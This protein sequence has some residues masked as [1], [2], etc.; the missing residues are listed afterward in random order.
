MQ[1]VLE[2]YRLQYAAE[3]P[4]VI[5]RKPGSSELVG[6]LQQDDV[7]HTVVDYK[8][9]GFVFAPFEGQD[10]VLLPL[11][12]ADMEQFSIPESA[13]DS[14]AGR[15]LDSGGQDQ[16][17]THEELVNSGIEAISKGLFQK[18]VLS[19][20]ERVKVRDFD[21]FETFLKLV[22]LYPSA[23]AY[24]FYHPRVGLWLGA[25]SEQLLYL[26]QLRF[27]T[28]AVAGTKV[29]SSEPISWGVKERREQQWVTD[30]IVGELQGIAAEVKVSKPYD[31]IAGSVV[32]L[33]TDISGRFRDAV[34]MGKLLEL[35][36]PTPAV[37]G[38][39]KK[40]A[41]DFILSH[42]GYDRKYYS[43]F[44]GEL[45]VAGVS[46]TNV[47]NLYVNLRC[48]EVEEDWKNHTAVVHSYIGGGIT[49]DSNPEKEWQE[50]VN[51]AQTIQ[52]IWK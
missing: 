3:L 8:E 4:F 46:G 6:M 10:I 17:R 27:Q 28:M 52:N 47:T 29:A 16:Q 35:L 33:K 12:A 1:N 19:R 24:C 15:L 34:D 20:K 49:I 30:F 11:D 23:F 7:L 9:R 22:T 2:K 18:V 5:Y 45:N 32:H 38:F 41:R 48:M 50:T 31:M 42:E 25:F 44:F 26:D 37:C 40:E 43:G 14:L 13:P 36:H 39:P 51:K 21:L